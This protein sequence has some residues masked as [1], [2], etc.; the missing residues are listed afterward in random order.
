M[1]EEKS[2]VQLRDEI[3]GIDRQIH[4]LLN[5]RAECAQQVALVK[6]R[7]DAAAVFYRPERE[8]Q[9]LRAVAQRNS[10]P[11]PDASVARLFREIMS[12]CLALEQP[13]TVAY[14]GPEGTF[15]QAAV[16]KQFG[17]AVATQPLAAI[18]E[19]FHEVESGRAAY[20]LVPVENSIGG[21]VTH[22]LDLF[23]NSTLSVCGE[24]VIR[25]HQQLL[26][27]VEQL[28]EIKRV[29]SHQQSLMQCRDWLQQ[30]L[31]EVE[32]IEV[33]SNAE[34]AKLAAAEQGS[35]AIA[36][37]SA[38]ELYQL[39]ILVANIEDNADNT[40]RF[41][42]IGEDQVAASG[43]D[44]TSLLVSTANRP[45]ALFELLQPLAEA[46]LSLSRIESRPSGEGLWKYLFFIDLEGHA[47]DEEVKSALAHLQEQ[48]ALFRLLGSYPQA[49]L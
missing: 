21:M 43:K 14:L 23:V 38:A 37:E 47:D 15:T 1:S 49:V 9:V 18:N 10:G 2:L 13:M 6:R 39:P 12:A 30:N 34:A 24:V 42:V 25:I 45:G 3:D 27:K 33:S 46:G 22:T 31:P 35:A 41:L 17:H 44:K 48:A 29:Y 36:S 11:L 5:R 28:S 40:T 7:S 19:V 26:S 8:A 20:G 4:T 16:I 32:R